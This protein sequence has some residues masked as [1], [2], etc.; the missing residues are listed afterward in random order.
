MTVT[1]RVLIFHLIAIE[2]RSGIKM[3]KAVFGY[4]FIAMVFVG[5]TVMYM[6]VFECSMVDM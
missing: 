3:A 1:M 6:T 5:G 2:S 4:N